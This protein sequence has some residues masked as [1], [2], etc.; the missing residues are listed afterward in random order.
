MITKKTLFILGAGASIPYGFPSGAELRGIL[1]GLDGGGNALF[2]TLAAM[3]IH[4]KSALRNFAR[5]FRL[6]KQASIDAFLAK[7][8][9]LAEIG[10][11]CI[12]AE[13]CRR[14]SVDILFRTPNEDDWHQTLWN[15]MQDGATDAAQIVTNNIRFVTFNYDR[16]L[17]CFLFHAIK[18]SFHVSEQDAHALMSRIPLRHVYGSLGQ[19]QWR[20]D[21]QGTYSPD[22]NDSSIIGIANCIKVIPE[23]RTDDKVFMEIREW[24]EW[25][26][27]VC[28]L[29]FGFDPLNMERLGVDSVFKYLSEKNGRLTTSIKA[30]RLGIT[31]PEVARIRNRYF[32]HV[33]DVFF[34]DAN[35][36]MTLRESGVLV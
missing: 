8:A 19:Y 34:H 21:L 30:S 27:Q 25:S 36:Q 22:V 11:I 6:S 1:C 9:D 14:E 2:G 7:R 20:A 32:K 15:A 31:E 13:L 24:V 16:S 4:S 10:K 23:L 18:S 17:E 12:A 35:V 3:E 28:F 29:G 33:G 5:D 26:E